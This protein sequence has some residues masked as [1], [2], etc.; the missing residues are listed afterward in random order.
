ML[1]TQSGDLLPIQSH[2]LLKNYA[3]N[4]IGMEKIPKRKERVNKWYSNSRKTRMS[5][6]RWGKTKTKLSET[7]VKKHP[8][9]LSECR[10][11]IFK[12]LNINHANRI[13]ICH[14]TIEL[15]AREWKTTIVVKTNIYGLINWL[16]SSLISNPVVRCYA[17]ATA[18]GCWCVEF[19]KYLRR[20]LYFLHDTKRRMEH[21]LRNECSSS[22]NL[23][24]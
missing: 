12:H 23:K 1:N 4:W 20:H 17:I 22:Y 24:C 6:V 9:Q 7:N 18:A 16:S 11:F 14:N 19:S 21:C 3:S 5:D 15:T 10:N 2:K 8:L 13:W